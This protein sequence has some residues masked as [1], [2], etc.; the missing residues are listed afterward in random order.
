MRIETEQLLGTLEV[1]SEN[2]RP[3]F[4]WNASSKGEFNIWNLIRDENFTEPVSPDLAVDSWIKEEQNH[5]VLI[6][7]DY[8]KEEPEPTKYLATATKIARENSYHSLLKL[9]KSNLQYIEAFICKFPGY[10]KDYYWFSDYSKQGYF[11][12]LIGKTYDNNWIAILPTVPQR[13]DY[14]EWICY[15]PLIETTVQPVTEEISRL[16]L[17]INEIL[18]EINPLKLAVCYPAGYSYSYNYQLFY[19]LAPS[20]ET[21]LTQAMLKTKIL[22]IDKFKKFL[23]SHDTYYY[24]NPTRKREQKL[25]NFLLQKFSDVRVYRISSYDIDYTYILGQ[26]AGAD[27][28]GVRVS[29]SYKYNP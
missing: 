11:Y 27:W 12:G 6:D 28:L 13:H 25:S 2:V 24:D 20:K 22:T 1:L 7:D 18:K 3:I 26:V 9:L 8:A 21:A 23:A 19:S 4:L 17:S 15:S 16:Q 14:P 29:R 5:N 10:D